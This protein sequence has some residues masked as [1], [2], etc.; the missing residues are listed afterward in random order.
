MIVRKWLFLI[1]LA[2]LVGVIAADR[3]DA[4]RIHAAPISKL[5]DK[6]LRQ[7]LAHARGAVS[8]FNN[9]PKGR[10]QVAI[11]FERCRAVAPVRR[12]TCRAARDS[13]NGHAWLMRTVQKK[14]NPPSFREYVDKYHPCLA[15]IIEIETAH[16]WEPTID[17]GSG[18]GNVDEA[19]GIPGANP[20]TKMKS[21]GKDWRTNPYTQLRWMIGYAN[22]RY[23]GECKALAFHRRNRWY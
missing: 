7:E 5:S 18:H 3:A 12:P 17:Y 19:Y 11:R 21:A 10:Y 6:Q 9:H 23:G 15:P 13:L 20:G 4:H 8:Y 22:K 2:C 16:T 14:L 1:A